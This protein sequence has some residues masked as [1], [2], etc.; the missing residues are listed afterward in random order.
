MEDVSAACVVDAVGAVGA[1]LAMAGTPVIAT[2]EATA[3]AA[4][5]SHDFMMYPRFVVGAAIFV[6]TIFLKQANYK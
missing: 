3:R 2:A 4:E 6:A 5:R 1:A